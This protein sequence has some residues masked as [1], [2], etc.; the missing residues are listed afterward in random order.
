MN[1]PFQSTILPVRRI[2]QAAL[3]AAVIVMAVGVS[4]AQD[5]PDNDADDG[6][7]I[8]SWDVAPLK[9][10]KTQGDGWGALVLTF[11]GPIEG[12]T[13]IFT[14]DCPNP[15]PG[16][17]DPAS[18]TDGGLSG[19]VIQLGPGAYGLVPG[20]GYGQFI[21]TVE[22]ENESPEPSITGA[23]WQS[24]PAPGGVRTWTI[25]GD[26]TFD[27]AGKDLSAALPEPSSVLLSAFGLIALIGYAWRK[28][29]A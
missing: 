8:Y 6:T 19:T 7:H 23:F 27:G 26:G 18:S 29:K 10:N 2:C 15:L 13:F 5:G 3:V 11:S 16:K 9:A 21:V 4:K 25:N 14:P 12:A 1:L 28:R 20:P 24:K 22:F 17:I